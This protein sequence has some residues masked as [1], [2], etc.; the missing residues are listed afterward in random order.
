MTSLSMAAIWL[1]WTLI[2]LEAVLVPALQPGAPALQTAHTHS[3]QVA[4]TTIWLHLKTHG[5]GHNCGHGHDWGHGHD[6]GHGHGHKITCM[7]EGVCCRGER[8]KVPST[9]GYLGTVWS[10]T[11]QYKRNYTLVFIRLFKLCHEFVHQIF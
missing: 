6:C 3:R 7:Q 1:R 2:Y 4:L 10:H 11:T 5:H 9:S 8:K